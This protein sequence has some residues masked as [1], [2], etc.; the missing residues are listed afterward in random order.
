MWQ[1]DEEYRKIHNAKM[2]DLSVSRVP[3]REETQHKT[4]ERHKIIN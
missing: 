4:G 3:E 2:S 1:K